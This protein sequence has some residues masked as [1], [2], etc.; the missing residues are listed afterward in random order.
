L[1]IRA[2]SSCVTI[3]LG[4]V[5]MHLKAEIDWRRLFHGLIGGFDAAGLSPVG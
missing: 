5:F 4:S 3:G 1:R 2:A